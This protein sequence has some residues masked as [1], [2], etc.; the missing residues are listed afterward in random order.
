MKFSPLFIT[1]TSLD[2]VL[3]SG[4]KNVPWLKELSPTIRESTP[5]KLL[6]VNVSL[7]PVFNP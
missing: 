7:S 3:V 1:N 2:N 5:A 4:M 6:L